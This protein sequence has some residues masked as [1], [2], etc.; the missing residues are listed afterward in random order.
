MG[1][2]VKEH[3]VS[4]LSTLKRQTTDITRR[5]L[6]LGTDFVHP[7]GDNPPVETEDGERAEE[8]AAVELPHTDEWGPGYPT[9]TFIDPATGLLTA[10]TAGNPPLDEAL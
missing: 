2:K 5:A 10:E 1:T 4:V 6:R 3:H 9:V 8:A 7:V